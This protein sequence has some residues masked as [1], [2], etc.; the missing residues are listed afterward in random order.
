MMERVS[1]TLGQMLSH[2]IADDKKNW[3]EM[4][5]EVAGGNK[6]VRGTTLAPNIV[7]V[8]RY[9]RLPIAHDYAERARLTGTSTMN[10]ETVALIS[11]GER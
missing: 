2:L 11:T 5:H 8:G 10:A 1:R 7:H 9:A 3:D 6:A 4:S